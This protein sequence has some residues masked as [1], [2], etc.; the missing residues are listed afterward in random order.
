MGPTASGKSA[1]AL[2]LAQRLGGDVINADALQVYGD[3]RVLSNRPGPEELASAPHKLFGHVDGAVRYHVGQWLQEARA[4]IAASWNAGRLV[5]VVGGTGLYFKALTQGLSP[6]PAIDPVVRARLTEQAAEGGPEALHQRLQHLDPISAARLAP[7]DSSR[8][9]R[10]LEVVL[11]T[12]RALPDFQGHADG[13]L[14]PDAWRGLCL[15]SDRE[16][17]R[18]RIAARFEIMLAQGAL[19][20]AAR[21]AKRGLD[22]ALPI[23]KAHGA[24][25]LMAHLAG[26]ISLAQ[27]A[28]LAVR[29]TQRYAK[30]QRTWMAHQ[31]ADWPR[32]V[33]EDLNER[34]DGALAI[35]LRPQS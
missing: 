5:L 16:I 20:E 12:G 9:V 33:S 21:L 13:A 24:P 27:A 3:L 7:T 10:A 15:C 34:A 26:E 14:A 11:S 17:L 35:W 2:E 28:A 8:I 18:A 22:K 23:A 30:R 4:A 31:M 1:L 6:V 29:D 25:W 32:I 19:E